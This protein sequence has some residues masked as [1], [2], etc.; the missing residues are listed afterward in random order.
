MNTEERM[1]GGGKEGRKVPKDVVG[2]FLKPQFG[3]DEVFKSSLKP[4]QEPRMST[5]AHTF[6]MFTH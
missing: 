3:L 4:P 5:A 1:K 2:D 6:H